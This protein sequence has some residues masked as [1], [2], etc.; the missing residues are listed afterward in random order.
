MCCWPLALFYSLLQTLGVAYFFAL[1]KT[2]GE[3]CVVY[4]LSPIVTLF[5]LVG[6]L[7]PIL[8]PK[9]V[10][11]DFFRFLGGRW[12]RRNFDVYFGRNA[13][14][15]CGNQCVLKLE[16]TFSAGSS[17]NK[18]VCSR[19]LAAH[20]HQTSG[21]KVI[22]DT[23]ATPPNSEITVCGCHIENLDSRVLISSH[24][25]WHS[26]LFFFCAEQSLQSF[27]ICFYL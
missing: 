2:I 17:R 5:G 21:H 22:A 13:E 24:F 11:G 27:T 19:T 20:P 14:K 9:N 1:F 7:F 23:S 26:C 12:W 15:E 8:D 10:G 6:S 16:L 18:C 3:T 25:F 4:A